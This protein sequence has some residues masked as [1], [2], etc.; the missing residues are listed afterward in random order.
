MNVTNAANLYITTTRYVLLANPEDQATWSEL[1]RYLPYLRQSL[2]CCVCANILNVPY[3]PYDSTCQHHVCKEC[4]G[5]KMRLKPSCSWCKDYS[6]FVE[7]PP[8]RM[9]IQCFRKFCEYIAESPLARQ[10]SGGASN[11]GTNALMTIVREGMDIKDDFRCNTNSTTFSLFPHLPP[12]TSRVSRGS[13]HR[14]RTN[15]SITKHNNISTTLPQESQTENDNGEHSGKESKGTNTETLKEETENEPEK[16]KDKGENL[17]HAST[18]TTVDEHVNGDELTESESEALPK[19][20]ERNN[21]EQHSN[22]ETIPCEVSIVDI[23]EPMN[24]L[25]SSTPP[26][27]ETKEKPAKRRRHTSERSETSGGT[28]K[29]LRLSSLSENHEQSIFHTP[30]DELSTYT[31]PPV[32]EVM[33]PK[34]ATPP[35]TT[36]PLPVKESKTRNKKPKVKKEGCRCGMATPNPGKLTCCGQRCPCYSSHKGC[37]DCRCRGCRNPRQGPDGIKILPAPPAVIVKQETP[38]DDSDIDIDV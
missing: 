33:T 8:L 36:T 34:P 1:Y 13:P 14:S 19:S 11:G 30:N 6:K 32:A 3:G 29:R 17:V 9:M 38:S 22:I 26:E 7:S 4:V 35:Q 16:V 21:I 20:E 37:V 31:V 24:Q 12:V 18:Q 2:S 15:S 25:D 10:L 23:L 28:R 5:G 27:E